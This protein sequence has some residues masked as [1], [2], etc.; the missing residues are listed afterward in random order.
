M[1]KINVRDRNKNFPDRKANWEY[2]FETA[3]INGK[4]QFTRCSGF[5]TKKAALEAGT[6][7][8][9]DY[10]NVGRSF[11]MSEISMADFLDYWLNNYVII[12]TASS[13]YMNYK[14]LIN[15]YIKP[16]IGYYKLKSIDSALL[17]NSINA[18]YINQGLTKSTLSNIVKLLKATLKYACSTTKFIQYN[19]ALDISLPKIVEVKGK[20]KKILEQ[21]DIEKILERFKSSP[22]QYYAI[23][24]SY[25]TGMRIAEVY[26]LTWDCIDWDKKTIT[27]NKI[28]KRLR[29]D[30]DNK[31]TING[32][33]Q[34]P[35]YLGDCKTLSSY[36]VI[37]VGDAL[38]S[39]LLEYKHWQDINKQ[40]Y[41]QYYIQHYLIEEKTPANRTVYR[42][43]STDSTVGYNLPYPKADLVMVKENGDF[44]GTDVM[45]YTAKVAKY[46]LGIQFNFHELRHT[47]ATRLI[48]SGAPI[49]DVQERLGHSCIATTMNTYVEDTDKMKN[50]TV[51][52]F[53]SNYK[54][55]V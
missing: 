22:Q 38:L 51:S 23:L 27:I 32:K 42:I 7:A 9:A 13:T 45:K 17:Q 25:Y 3:K 41:E 39:K 33:I 21:T 49:K 35:W 14:Y 24:I 16:Q 2:Y 34:N 11:K 18:I 15:H 44:K 47:H 19:P 10:Y 52:L 6:K 20:K 53:E 36:R 46:E 26:G 54:L 12:N 55:S 4:R 48:E 43:I 50:Q 28:A 31:S 30:Y 29:Y 40:K 5:T 1:A 37:K 8:M